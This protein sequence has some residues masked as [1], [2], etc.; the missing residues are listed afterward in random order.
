[1]VKFIKVDDKIINIHCIK[2]IES[3]EEYAKVYSKFTFK[4][5]TIMRTHISIDELYKLIEDCSKN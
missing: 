5:G 4:D 1:M 3:V 2:H